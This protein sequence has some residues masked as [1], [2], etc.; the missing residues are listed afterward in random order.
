LVGLGGELGSTVTTT[1]IPFD[2][3]ETGPWR[4]LHFPQYLGFSDATKVVHVN[5]S[6]FESIPHFCD[7]IVASDD[8]V[9]RKLSTRVRFHYD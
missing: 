6:T 8:L 1:D 4:G 7:K 2:Y 5:A 3:H 9:R